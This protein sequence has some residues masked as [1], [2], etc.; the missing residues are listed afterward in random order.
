MKELPNN[1][2]EKRGFLRKATATGAMLIALAGCSEPPIKEGA[3]FRKQYVEAH[4]EKK[5]VWMKV[6]QLLTYGLF[7]VTENVPEKW[8]VQIAQCPEGALPPQEKIEEE[9]KINS[10]DV[11]QE[12]YNSLQIGHYADFKQTK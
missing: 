12:V 4:T 9:C 8:T 5:P 2:Q 10:F 7:N 6:G 11:P 3:V 1:Y